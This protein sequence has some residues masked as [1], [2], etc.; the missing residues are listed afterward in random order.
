MK[1]IEEKDERQASVMSGTCVY[2][3]K[4][5]SS[6]RQRLVSELSDTSLWQPAT[7][8]LKLCKKCHRELP[9]SQFYDK[10]EKQLTDCYCKECRKTVNR[11]NRKIRICR[12]ATQEKS[13]RHPVITDIRQPEVRMK[14]ILNALC[15]VRESILRKNRKRH[16]EEFEQE[17]D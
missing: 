11:L 9:Y 1:S 17:C 6:S 4:G 10:R 14:L 2:A 7:Q 3:D 16:E 5:Q 13:L 8:A 12:C 15:T